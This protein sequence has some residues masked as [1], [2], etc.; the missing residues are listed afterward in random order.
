[1]ELEKDPK[2]PKKF[3]EKWKIL[4]T[5]KFLISNHNTKLRYQKNIVL[6]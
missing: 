4:N 2:Y 5:L 1:M 3:Q 6:A